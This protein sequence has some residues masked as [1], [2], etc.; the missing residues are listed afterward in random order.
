MFPPMFLMCQQECVGLYDD[1]YGRVLSARVETHL[2][3]LS[4]M[5]I[6]S[7]EAPLSILSNVIFSNED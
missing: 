5:L 6:S 2:C 1:V 7:M 4:V 3:S